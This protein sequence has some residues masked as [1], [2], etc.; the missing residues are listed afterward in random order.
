[1]IYRTLFAVVGL[2]ALLLGLHG[3]FRTGPNSDAES[4][5]RVEEPGFQQTDGDKGGQ[6]EGVTALRKE[7]SFLRAELNG[8]RQPAVNEEIDVLKAQIAALQR[9]RQGESAAQPATTNGN[10]AEEYGNDAVDAEDWMS[11]ERAE[12]QAAEQRSALNTVFEEETIDADWSTDAT[13][14]LERAFASEELSNAS[15]HSA[16]CRST[17]CRVDVEHEDPEKA[18]EFEMWFGKQIAEMLP[19]FSLFQEEVDGRAITVVYLARDGH[20]LPNPGSQ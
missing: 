17:L 19:R 11:A 5:T 14:A 16:E 7:L 2:A 10:D 15:V 4:L 9:E 13:Q 6:H 1:M 20:K 8:L 12:Q 18:G 3:N